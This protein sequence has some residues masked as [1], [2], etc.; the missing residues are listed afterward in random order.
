MCV[1]C[2]VV[3]VF[4]FMVPVS[5]VPPTAVVQPITTSDTRDFQLNSMPRIAA[6]QR[7]I[8]STIEQLPRS[9]AEAGIL[10]RGL[11]TFVARLSLA[12]TEQQAQAILDEETDK[13]AVAVKKAPNAQ[14]LIDIMLDIR[15]RNYSPE[16]GIENDS[17]LIEIQSSANPLRQQASSLAMHLSQMNTGLMLQHRSGWL[18]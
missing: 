12:K 1:S 15:E 2:L 18:S 6:A 10:R 16:K 9:A 3:S 11:N 7:E 5:D 13:L 14:Q 4:T 8:Q 17:G